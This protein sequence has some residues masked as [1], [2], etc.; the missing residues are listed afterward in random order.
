MFIVQCSIVI[1]HLESFEVSGERRIEGTLFRMPGTIQ[2]IDGHATV[3]RQTVE[4][5]WDHI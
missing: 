5:S 4:Q 3:T 1:C 2:S